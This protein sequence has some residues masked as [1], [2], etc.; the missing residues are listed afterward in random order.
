LNIDLGAEEAD[1]R[2]QAAILL[3]HEGEELARNGDLKGAADKYEL[4]SDLNP[5]P[6]THVY[7]RVS[8]GSFKMG[9]LDDDQYAG[10]EEKPQ[11]DVTLSEFW[12]L[13][14]EVTNAQYRE[15]VEAKQKGDPRGCDPPDNERWDRDRLKYW[16][17]TDVTWYQANTYAKWL[18]GRLP[19]EAEWEKACRG[20]EASVYPWGDD[21][22][23]PKIANVSEYE[24]TLTDVGSYPNGQ[25]LYGL[26]DMAGNVW[27]WTSSK[28]HAYPYQANDG[29]EE[30]VGDDD[31]ISRGGSFSNGENVVRCAA[32]YAIRPNFRQYRFGFR[33]VAP[34]F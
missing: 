25:S 30:Q 12:I 11:H 4:A 7:V 16:P 26:R 15:C 6:D 17:V 24:I 31:R 23:T 5:P 13:R 14:T 19:T 10:N 1:V 9:S 29:R 20:T 22:P 34:G 18:G 28:Y 8:A 33:I 3:V 27:E 32:R 21:P 2:R